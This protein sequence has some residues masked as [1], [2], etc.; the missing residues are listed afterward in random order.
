MTIF[1]VGDQVQII[2]SPPPSTTFEAMTNPGWTER[3]NK[4]LGTKDIIHDINYKGYVLL[5]GNSYFFHPNWIT[6]IGEQKGI[7]TNP[8]LARSLLLEQRFKDRKK[9]PT[10]HH[11]PVPF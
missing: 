7:P 5:Q 1:N 9:K 10:V 3:M 11:I 4:Y 6:K 2:S 8:I